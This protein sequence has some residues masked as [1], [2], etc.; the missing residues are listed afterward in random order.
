MG[1]PSALDKR[2]IPLK[3]HLNSQDFVL[4]LS[5]VSQRENHFM[6]LG[7]LLLLGAEWDSELGILSLQPT[8]IALPNP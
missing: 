8:E 1:K 6:A 5:P 3:L 2:V 4:S 7:L